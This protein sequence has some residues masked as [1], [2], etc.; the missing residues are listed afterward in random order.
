MN[1]FYFLCLFLIVH[2]F[3]YIIIIYI[4]ERRG[5]NPIT[6]GT[7]FG[8]ID[9]CTTNYSSFTLKYIIDLLAVSVGWF[10]NN[11]FE[12]YIFFFGVIICYA[13]L[14][15]ASDA[16][17]VFTDVAQALH[18]DLKDAIK[19]VW[20]SAKQALNQIL[21]S[22]NMIKLLELV[23]IGTFIICVPELVNFLTK[24]FMKLGKL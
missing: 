6:N 2:F 7:V 21:I 13:I 1:L 20:T 5:L 19:E 3:E 16:R 4:C 22:V 17:K 9:Y 18:I 14:N 11:L 23:F 12:T 8:S 24:T 15:S 10:F